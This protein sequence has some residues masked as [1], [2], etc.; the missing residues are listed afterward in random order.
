MSKILILGDNPKLAKYYFDLLTSA[1]YIALTTNNSNEFFRTYRSFQPDLL[2]LD[3]RL[4]N[5]ELSGLQ[6]FEKLVEENNLTAKVII[7]SGEASRL[8]VTKAMQLGAH[9]FIEKSGDFSAEKFLID[10]QQAINLKRQEEQVTSL[11]ND[12]E[13]LRRDLMIGAPLIGKSL[14]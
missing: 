10:I 13:K 7:L 9:T 3:I 1:A 11:G 5:S 6:V 14:P 2:I 12:K 8:E 4:N